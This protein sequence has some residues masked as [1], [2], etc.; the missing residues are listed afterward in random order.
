MESKNSVLVFLPDERITKENMMVLA[1]ELINKIP[2]K[3]FLPEVEVKKVISIEEMIDR[4]TDRIH[5]SLNMNFKEFAGVGITKE[6]KV[7]VIVSFLAML[8]LVRVG[9]VHVIQ[10]N[11]FEDIIINKREEGDNRVAS[12]EE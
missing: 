1:Q 7:T 11:N 9:V 3:V 2:K 6:E 4:L 12:N 8:E 5:K 10:E